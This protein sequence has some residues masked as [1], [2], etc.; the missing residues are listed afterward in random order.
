MKANITAVSALAYVSALHRLN[1]C[2]A[3]FFHVGAVCKTALIRIRRKLAEQFRKLFLQ[4]KVYILRIKGGKSRGIDC[5]RAIGKAEHFHMAGSM[6]TA[7]QL[8]ADF[9]GLYAEIG[10]QGIEQTRLSYAGIS[11]KCAGMA[12][13]DLR[14]FCYPFARKGTGS[15]CFKACFCVYCLLF[16]EILCDFVS[17]LSNHKLFVCG[18]NKYLYL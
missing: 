12:F 14:Q 8:F 3:Q 13:Y 15:Y 6:A 9:A 1:N 11:R 5:R 16:L 7:P 2:A 4:F 17:I 18:D 10:F